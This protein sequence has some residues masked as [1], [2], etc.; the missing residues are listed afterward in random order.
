MAI[1]GPQALPMPSGEWHVFH[2]WSEITS[3]MH[4]ANEDDLSGR[5]VDDVQHEVA[6]LDGHAHASGTCTMAVYFVGLRTIGAH[7]G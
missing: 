2:Q 3:R 1:C 7:V 6:S 5:F 4:H